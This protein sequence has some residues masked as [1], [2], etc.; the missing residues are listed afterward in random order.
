MFLEKGAAGTGFEIFFEVESSVF[1]G[2]CKVGDEFDWEKGFGSWNIS[3]LVAIDS[4]FEI[5]GTTRIWL[6]VGALENVD[7][8]H[9]L[10]ITNFAKALSVDGEFLLFIRMNLSFAIYV[11]GLC[12]P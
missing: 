11:S 3:F 9:E 5:V 4:F 12:P 8:V 2:K 7:V 6:T 1:V 10:S